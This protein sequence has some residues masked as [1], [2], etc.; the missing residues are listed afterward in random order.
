MVSDQ[1]SLGGEI[2]QAPPSFSVIPSNGSSHLS[3]LLSESPTGDAS[4]VSYLVNDGFH[5]L[6]IMVKIPWLLYGWLMMVNNNDWL[7]VE[8]PTPLKN[9]GVSSSVGMIFHSQ[10]NGKIIHVPNHQPAFVMAVF[11]GNMI[12]RGSCWILFNSHG[13]AK[14]AVTRLGKRTPSC[15]RSHQSLPWCLANAA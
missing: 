5:I 10:L 15:R 14:L 2:I 12:N 3:V 9:H 1:D 11:I 4:Q 6:L 7:V 13:I 8:P